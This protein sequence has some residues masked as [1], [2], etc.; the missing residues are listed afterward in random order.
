MALAISPEVIACF[1]STSDQESRKR[2]EL[3][4]SDLNTFMAA[5]RASVA[6]LAFNVVTLPANIAVF[7]LSIISTC[8]KPCCP[9]TFIAPKTS[10][11]GVPNFLAKL[12]AVL[13]NE[14]KSDPIGAITIL[15][16]A[17]LVSMSANVFTAC[18]S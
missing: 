13:C 2:I 7:V 8:F 16:W 11:M 3:S 10:V 14:S 12:T 18:F 15:S 6:S 9:K 1:D 17:I 4:P 5:V